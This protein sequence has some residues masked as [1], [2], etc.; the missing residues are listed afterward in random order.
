MISLLRKFFVSRLLVVA[1]ILA[2]I[3]AVLL[4]S[5][6]PQQISSSPDTI[7]QWRLQYPVLVPLSEFLQLHGIY[8]SYWFVWAIVLAGISLG[9]ST[10]EQIRMARGRI[11][12]INPSGLPLVTMHGIGPGL[13]QRIASSGYRQ[14]F[15]GRDGLYKFIRCKWG[16]WGASLFHFGMVLVIGASCFIALTERRGALTIAQHEMLAPKDAWTSTEEGVLAKKLRL[17]ATFRFDDLRIRYDKRSA[18]EHI[19]SLV[20]F[21]R[22][23]GTEEHGTVAVNGASSYQGVRIYHANEYGDAFTLEFTE[24]DGRHHVEKLLIPHPGGL[25]DA[26]YLDTKLPWLPFALSSKYSADVEQRS[27]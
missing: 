2:V 12:A 3:A 21:I 8:T 17:P 20:T 25:A 5:T 16:Y 24:P 19:E 23:D 6:I 9:F 18:P 26:G 14:Q 1:E 27:I 15:T 11:V 4:A 22:P 10:V 7:S 13:V